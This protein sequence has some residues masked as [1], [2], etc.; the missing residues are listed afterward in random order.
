MW[1]PPSNTWWWRL[2]AERIETGDESGAIRVAIAKSLG[3]I[4]D[5]VSQ[6]DKSPGIR[7]G[8][9]GNLWR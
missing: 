1:A 5:G 7:S 9:Q 4:D 2:R 3:E 8:C 6:A